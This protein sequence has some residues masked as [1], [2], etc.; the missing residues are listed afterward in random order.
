MNNKR[1]RR[2]PVGSVSMPKGIWQ[3]PERTYLQYNDAQNLRLKRMRGTH[4]ARKVCT[5][6]QSTYSRPVATD[7]QSAEGSGYPLPL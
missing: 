6:E 4:S 2:A 5:H 1:H 3:R 7:G